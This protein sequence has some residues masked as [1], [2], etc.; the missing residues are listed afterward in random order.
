[1]LQYLKELSIVSIFSDFQNLQASVNF[2]PSFL[3]I[4]TSAHIGVCEKSLQGM[5]TVSAPFGMLD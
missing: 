4:V 5:V 3:G 2:G 1:M